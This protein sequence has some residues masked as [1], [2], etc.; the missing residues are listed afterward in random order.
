MSQLVV[1]G[2]RG[3]QFKLN[4]TQFRSPLAATINSVQT[5]TMLQHFPIRAGQPDIQFTV[6][7]ASMDDK[8][9]WQDFVR[10]HQRNAQSDANGMITLS[11][12]ERNIDNWTGYITSL[13]VREEWSVFAPRMTFGVM[14]V[15]SL[16]S[17]RTRMSSSG[18]GASSLFGIQ[19]PS[20]LSPWIAWQEDAL[21]RPPTG[22][23]GQ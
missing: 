15:D 13:P 20:L 6:Q 11:W 4:V 5:K 22:S 17:Q 19:I 18:S 7:F 9:E 23:P 12:P 10:D 2:H 8:H 1:N 3:S 21:L 14:L 16:V